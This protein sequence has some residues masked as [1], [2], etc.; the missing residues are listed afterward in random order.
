VLVLIIAVVAVLL[1]LATSPSEDIFSSSS[2]QTTTKAVTTTTPAITTT[3]HEV[4]FVQESNCPYGSWLF[5]WGVVVG[6]QAVVQPSNA[7]LPLSYSG[8]HLTSDSNYSTIWF[9]LPNGTYNYTI[10]PNDPLGSPQSGNI[11]VDGGNVVVQ[12]Y[13]FSTAMGCSSSTSQ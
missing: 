1:V 4:E 12:V 5:P 11:T 8:S 6:S 13:A 3:S 2:F 10:I 7:T 9:S